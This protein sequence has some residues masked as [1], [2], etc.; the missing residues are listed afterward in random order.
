MEMAQEGAK[1]APK[2]D[3]EV[4]VHPEGS[5]V[6]GDRG[7]QDLVPHDPFPPGRRKWGASAQRPTR[8]GHAGERGGQEAAGK[9]E[10]TSLQK[11]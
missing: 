4:A 3:V 8:R 9:I 11:P 6:V 1:M 2:N 5:G 7:V 10:Q